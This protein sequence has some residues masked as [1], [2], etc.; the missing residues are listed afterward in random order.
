MEPPVDI[1]GLI[2]A[3]KDVIDE[4]T[5]HAMVEEFHGDVET[6]FHV[7]RQLAEARNG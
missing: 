5:I 2:A 1:D 3:F 6:A 4:A 7:L